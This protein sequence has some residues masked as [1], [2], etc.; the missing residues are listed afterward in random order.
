MIKSVEGE[1]VNKGIHSFRSGGVT[2]AAGS[3]VDERCLKRHGRW[4]SDSAK[5]G[6]IL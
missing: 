6:Y 3:D 4:V 1:H 2:V 5:D